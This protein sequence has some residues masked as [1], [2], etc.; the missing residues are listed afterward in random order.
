ML[1]G[2]KHMTNIMRTYQEG[3]V[4]IHSDTDEKIILKRNLEK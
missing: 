2:M 1:T 4:A 3:A